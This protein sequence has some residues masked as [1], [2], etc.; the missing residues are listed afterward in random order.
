MVIANSLGLTP[1]DY[2]I[3]AGHRKIVQLLV[4]HSSFKKKHFVFKER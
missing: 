2:A 3:S 1:V 4:G